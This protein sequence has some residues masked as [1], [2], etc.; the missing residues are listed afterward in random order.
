MIVIRAEYLDFIIDSN[1]REIV[2][3]ISVTLSAS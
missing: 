2:Q 1:N 3:R